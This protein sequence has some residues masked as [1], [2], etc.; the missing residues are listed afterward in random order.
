MMKRKGKVP[1][2]EQVEKPIKKKPM[3]KAKESLKMFQWMKMD[4]NKHKWTRR[5]N[6]E[7]LFNL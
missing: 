3:S 1:I 6:L 7:S 5:T 4:S 2:E